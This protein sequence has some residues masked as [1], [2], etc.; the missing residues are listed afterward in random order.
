M[1]TL[2]ITGAGGF[3]GV[4]AAMYYKE[5]VQ[6]HACTRPMLDVSDRQAVLREM[7]ALRPEAVLHCAAIADTLYAQ[8]HPEESERINLE[9]TRNMAIACAQVGARLVYIS[10]DQVYTGC[11]HGGALREEQAHPCNVYGVHKL[12]AEQA[13]QDALPTAVGLRLTW[14][15]DL[16]ESPYKLNRNVLVNLRAASQSGV[17]LRGSTRDFRGLT[18]VWDVVKR[19]QACFALPGGVYNFGSE[20]ARD[21]LATLREAAALCGYDPARVVTPDDTAVRN[22]WMDCEKLRAHGVAF[23]D[24]LEGLR[25]AL[26]TGEDDEAGRLGEDD[27]GLHPL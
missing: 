16:P 5:R 6:V 3:L 4:R 22:L 7:E 17:P 27:R 1:K 9:G 2:L 18:N 15:Y 20:N 13:A 23:P 10:S 25:R 12:A 26:R 24:T 11:T 21:M 14:M 19:L 8:N